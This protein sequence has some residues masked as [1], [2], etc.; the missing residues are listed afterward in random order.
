MWP[1]WTWVCTVLWLWQQRILS[2]DCKELQSMT[3]KWTA[4]H[5][6]CKLVVASWKLLLGF[7][8]ES[9]LLSAKKSIRIKLKYWY[10]IL[11]IVMI[12]S[13]LIFI[14]PLGSWASL[15]MLA[16]CQDITSIISGNLLVA[17]YGCF[18]NPFR[19][20]WLF[21]ALYWEY[22]PTVPL[23]EHIQ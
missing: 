23:V 13:L 19:T 16:G 1:L 12:G 4:V 5:V 6:E 3:S 21:F 14:T 15:I 20:G 22:L 10:H 2:R 8:V 7:P 11:C 9:W 17:L 18:A